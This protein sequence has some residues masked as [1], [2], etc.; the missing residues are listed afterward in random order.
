MKSATLAMHIFFFQNLEKRKSD[1]ND[2][3]FGRGECS[4]HHNW[5]LWAICYFIVYKCSLFPTNGFS[6]MKNTSDHACKLKN[7]PI[8]KITRLGAEMGKN[9][10]VI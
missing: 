6:V 10:Q 2:S 7:I 8:F 9:K 3:C 5:E 4:V 1:I